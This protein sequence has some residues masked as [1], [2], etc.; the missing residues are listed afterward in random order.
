MESL[1]GDT[2]CL[3]EKHHTFTVAKLIGTSVRIRILSQN[4]PHRQST[5]CP[6][7]PCK[8][9]CKKHCLNP[10]ECAKEV[11]RRVDLILPKLY[12]SHQVYHHGNLSLMRMRKKLNV[13]ARAE[14][15]V[16]LFDLTITTRN[17]C[18]QMLP[19]LHRPNQNIK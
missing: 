5:Y 6:C 2:R 14:N 11:K 19:N 17:N 7:N 1:S 13:R 4:N 16:I 18:S 3:I 12:P 10:D 9:N 8:N 15:G